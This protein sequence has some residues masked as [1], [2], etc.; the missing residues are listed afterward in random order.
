MPEILAPE[1]AACRQAESCGPIGEQ[2]DG[3]EDAGSAVVL[4]NV[5]GKIIS[6]ASPDVSIVNDLLDPV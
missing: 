1:I 4:S 6:Y 3:I 2:L 5:E